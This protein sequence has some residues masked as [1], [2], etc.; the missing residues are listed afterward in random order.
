MHFDH[1]TR[2]QPDNKYPKGMPRLEK[3]RPKTHLALFA[4]VVSAA[5]IA[6]SLPQPLLAQYVPGAGAGDWETATPT[7]VGWNESAVP[8]LLTYLED[9]ET[10]AFV[11]LHD[12]RI[13]IEAYFNGFASDSTWV[14]YSAGKSLTAALVGLAQQE[15]LLSISDTTTEH[16][17]RWTLMSEEQE[18]RITIRHQLTMTTGLDESVSFGCTLRICVKYL[19]DPG[20]R[21]VYHNAPYSLLRSVLESA[22]GEDIND[23]TAA[24]L[25]A[26]I[27]LDGEWVA[28]GYNNFYYSTARGA[29][30]F[31]LLIE[32]GGEW[33]T[34]TVLTDTAY[35]REMTTPSQDLNPS[36]GYLWWLNGQSTYIAPESPESLPGPLAP[37]APADAVVAAGAQGQ[38]ISV[39]P[40]HDLVWVRMGNNP[41]GGYVPTDYHESIW[42]RLAP[43]IGYTPTTL[44]DPEEGRGRAEELGALEVYPNPAKARVWVETRSGGDVVVYDVLGRR[45]FMREATLGAPTELDIAH[46]KPGVYYIVHQSGETSLARRSVVV[47]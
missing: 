31:G 27:G 43:V 21:W 41:S 20:S 17:G 1:S 45:V 35:V 33:G 14:W 22:S 28:S 39:V 8:E 10:R 18:E 23:Y 46:L 30:R 34:T 16:L 42:Q 12:G 36:Y 26:S 3:K 7:S 29:A 40:S 38:F 44:E 13:V 15:G 5:L 11:A 24:R 25:G 4:L 32:R 37:S 9:T 47:Q 2:E 19:A 6:L